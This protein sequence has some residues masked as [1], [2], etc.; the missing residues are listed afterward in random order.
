LEE[1]GETESAERAEVRARVRGFIESIEFEPGQAVEKGTLLYRIQPDE[2]QAAVQSAEAEVAA[3]RA[4][5]SVA[6]AE[7]A[8][9]EAEVNRAERELQRQRSLKAQ[10]A[11]SQTELDEAIAADES[12]KA[13]LESA[14][15]AIEAAKAQLQQ[16]EARLSRAKLDLSYTEVR[17]P[18]AGEVTKAEVKLGN[19][20]DN[21]TELT[22]IV[23][24]SRIFAN[25]N[26]S[27][28]QLLRFLE[29][30]ADSPQSRPPERE[31]WQQTPVFLSREIDEGYP[32]EGRLDYIDREGID[33]GTGTLGLRAAF[34]NSNAQLVPGLF[35]TVQIP[36]EETSD[37]LIV[38]ELAVQ[39]DRVGDYVLAVTEQAKVE[40][41]GVGVGARRGGW[42]VIETG[43]AEGD[44]IVVEGLQR[45]RPGAAVA[46]EPTELDVN[47]DDLFSRQQSGKNKS[48]ESEASSPDVPPPSNR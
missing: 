21:G 3:A 19:L 33:A 4:A 12:A 13:R 16:A 14:T 44:R 11:T 32:F 1:T 45:A 20:V 41:R 30:Q 29:R 34:D 47:N 36:L 7:K 15:S 17:A 31:R 43:L 48:G 6:T 10:D 5:I 2:Y 42:A 39:R 37:A 46:P 24:D 28:R 40:R 26:V 38:P 35:V 23:D 8:T 27:D 9:A 18:I 25:F 22:A